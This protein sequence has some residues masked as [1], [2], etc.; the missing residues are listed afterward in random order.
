MAGEYSP[1]KKS[2]NGMHGV[3][4][5]QRGIIFVN[6]SSTVNRK[7]NISTINSPFRRLDIDRPLSPNH[8]LTTVVLFFF[9]LE[10]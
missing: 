7:K 2:E 10:H 8:W 4:K 5:L 9:W 3:L 6:W 1:C